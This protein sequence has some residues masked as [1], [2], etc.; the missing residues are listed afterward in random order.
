MSTTMSARAAAAHTSKEAP[1]TAAEAIEQVA[2]MTGTSR[3]VAFHGARAGRHCLAKKVGLARRSV[4]AGT[5]SFAHLLTTVSNPAVPALPGLG[6]LLRRA[7]QR[8]VVAQ[9][10]LHRGQRQLPVGAGRE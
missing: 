5:P 1:T 4:N 10:L 9:A 7:A 8:A 2:P 6:Q 3:T